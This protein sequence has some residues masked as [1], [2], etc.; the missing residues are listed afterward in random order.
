MTTVLPSVPEFDYTRQRH[1]S[2]I[3]RYDKIL[4]VQ[5]LSE[6]LLSTLLTI[7]LQVKLPDRMVTRRL[8]CRGVAALF[9]T[10]VA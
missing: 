5:R 6:F 1:V 9:S 8:I 2:G 10:V 4:Q 3:L 7:Y